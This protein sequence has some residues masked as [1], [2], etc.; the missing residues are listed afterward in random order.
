MIVESIAQLDKFLVHVQTLMLVFA[1]II[2]IIV[3]I[4][5]I[6]III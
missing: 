6:I 5:I 1:I 3:I 4:V 2:V